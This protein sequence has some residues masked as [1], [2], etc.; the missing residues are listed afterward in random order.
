M[1]ARIF[2]T[3][4]LILSV[5]RK[6]ENTFK[7]DHRRDT[8]SD[9][10]NANSLGTASGRYDFGGSFLWSLYPVDAINKQVGADHGLNLHTRRTGNK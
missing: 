3:A 8:I 10:G 1:S 6:E 2:S 5:Q 4:T 7:T 9:N